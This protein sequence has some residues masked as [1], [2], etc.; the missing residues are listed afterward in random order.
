M[1]SKESIHNGGTSLLEI[2]HSQQHTLTL[3]SNEIIIDLFLSS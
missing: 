1:G 2:N 3:I